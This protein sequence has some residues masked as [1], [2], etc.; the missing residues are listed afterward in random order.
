MIKLHDIKTADTVYEPEEQF[1]CSIVNEDVAYDCRQ[2]LSFRPVPLSTAEACFCSSF[3][4]R[5]FAHGYAKL[6]F[7][8]TVTLSTAK[9]VFEKL[10]ASWSGMTQTE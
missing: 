8:S 4:P 7:T 9:D 5:H 1:T 6:S 10:S 3:D 2:L